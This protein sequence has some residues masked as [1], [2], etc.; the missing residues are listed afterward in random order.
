[1]CACVNP[2]ARTRPCTS[3]HVRMR[4][5]VYARAR[6][7]SHMHM[8]TRMCACTHA[9]KRAADLENSLYQH[10]RK[11]AIQLPSTLAP[12]LPDMPAKFCHIKNKQYK[13]TSLASVTNASVHSSVRP[14]IFPS[15][16]ASTH[17]PVHPPS[18]PIIHP[19]SSTI[20]LRTAAAASP[21]LLRNVQ[22]C[23][24][25]PTVDLRSRF[26]HRRS[27]RPPSACVRA[28]ASHDFTHSHDVYEHERGGAPRRRHGAAGGAG[29]RS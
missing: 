12:A 5:H 7:R 11:R 21:S 27:A 4:A 20:R 1:M 23:A 26:R 25:R 6:T 10:R 16:R 29:R 2:Y 18:Q 22:A 19:L 9:C 28:H 17:P 24:A 3:T 13:K 8:H 15:I 14:P